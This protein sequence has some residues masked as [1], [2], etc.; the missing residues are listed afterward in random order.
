MP[1]TDHPLGPAQDGPT[2]QLRAAQAEAAALRRQ[3]A[4]LEADLE[5][6]IDGIC[7]AAVH[8]GRGGRVGLPMLWRS[9][10]DRD[11]QP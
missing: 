4:A 11:P 7:Y 9:C 10:L 2:D 5:R 3:V 6:L 1:R 8:D